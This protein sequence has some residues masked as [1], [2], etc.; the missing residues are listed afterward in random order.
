MILIILLFCNN[1]KRCEFSLATHV[2][3]LFARGLF[4]SVYK[5]VQ[6]PFLSGLMFYFI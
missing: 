1:S 2:N 5:K 4:Y 6:G 3:L